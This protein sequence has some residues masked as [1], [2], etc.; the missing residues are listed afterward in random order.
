M[1]SSKTSPKKT[2]R[3]SSYPL[4]AFTDLLHA[5]LPLENGTP[6]DN[7]YATAQGVPWNASGAGPRWLR[8]TLN[9]FL[10]N[11]FAALSRS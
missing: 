4:E 10:N 1:S 8:C 9:Q 7:L 3:K 6:E 5:L 11:A 2:T